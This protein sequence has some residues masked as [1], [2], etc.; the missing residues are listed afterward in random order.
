MSALEEH[1]GVCLCN[2]MHIESAGPQNAHRGPCPLHRTHQAVH[3][4]QL[5]GVQDMQRV[6]GCA[7]QRGLGGSEQEDCRPAHLHGQLRGIG[8]KLLETALSASGRKI[9]SSLNSEECMSE[10]REE[11]LGAPIEHTRLPP[12]PATE[13]PNARLYVLC[14]SPASAVSAVRVVEVL[15]HQQVQVIRE[16][17]PPPSQPL[18]NYG[19]L[20]IP[21]GLDRRSHAAVQLQQVLVVEELRAHLGS[22]ALHVLRQCEVLRDA[23]GAVAEGVDALYLDV[24][25]KVSLRG[26]S[27]AGEQQ[28]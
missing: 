14:V 12:P 13:P 18:P 9:H 25:S 7:L 28:Q 22:A 19:D 23:E 1:L 10:V 2:G 8:N 15:V 16:L 3:V 6:A 20:G 11:R 4:L 21:Q 26:R 5:S 17:H 24:L 27:S